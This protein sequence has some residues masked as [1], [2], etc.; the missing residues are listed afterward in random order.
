MPESRS[1]VHE[2]ACPK[3]SAPAK[4]RCRTLASGR[5]TDTHEARWTA[6]YGPS[7]RTAPAVPR[8]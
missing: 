2:V 1:P 7:D 8:G 3:C 4:Q 6:R 5:T